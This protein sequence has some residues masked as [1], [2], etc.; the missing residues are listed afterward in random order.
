MQLTWTE[1]GFSSL[2]RWS[3]MDTSWIHRR[4]GSGWDT[5]IS[6]LAAEVG[7]GSL[8]KNAVNTISSLLWVHGESNRP[9]SP[10]V[11]TQRKRFVIT[12]VFAFCVYNMFAA[13]FVESLYNVSVNWFLCKGSG[14]VA[15]TQFLVWLDHWIC[16]VVGS[17]R[18]VSRNLDI[19]C[20]C[21]SISFCVRFAAVPVPLYADVT[22]DG[23]LAC[24]WWYDQ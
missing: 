16:W 8:S 24:Q 4:V 14:G 15:I 18:V 6:L 7:S 21:Q 19:V 23:V 9:M 1:K 11:D 13:W 5:D 2:L 20:L 12:E 3:E 17:G 10:V 22:D